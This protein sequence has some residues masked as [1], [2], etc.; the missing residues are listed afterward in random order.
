MSQGCFSL[1]V[2]FSFLSFRAFAP[3]NLMKIAQS[4]TKW[5]RLG[6]GEV[7]TTVEKLRLSSCLIRSVIE[8]IIGRRCL[9]LGERR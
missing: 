1:S 3:R 9:P 8:R 7:E 6:S 5:R 4:P 2:L